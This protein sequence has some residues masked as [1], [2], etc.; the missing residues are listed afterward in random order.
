MANNN[1]VVGLAIPYFILIVFTWFTAGSFDYTLRVPWLWTVN[2]AMFIF[3]G[4]LF[5]VPVFVLTIIFAAT[6][7]NSVESVAFGLAIPGFFLTIGGTLI[8]LYDTL[9]NYITPTLLLVFLLPQIIIAFGL[10]A[11]RNINE[12]NFQRTVPARQYPRSFQTIPR[13]TRRG[14]VR[15]SNEIR[16]A[17]TYGQ[18]VK[19]CVQ[20]G[21]TLDL[22]T[23][24][25]YFCGSRQPVV[26]T[27]PRAA[28]SPPAARPS[29]YQ[30]TQA[31]MAGQAF[32][33]C[34]NCG[35]PIIPGHMFCTQ[36]GASLD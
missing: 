8:A 27:R 6:K 2:G 9:I 19:K 5:F 12:R 22:K 11:Q 30:R 33:F 7:D 31:P 17:S 21:S 15:I 13:Q 35:A 1:T 25:C 23:Q 29:Y 4:C 34:P 24:V 32:S 14:G 18:A 26:H 3:F 28:R 10:F 16:M 20:C 36:C